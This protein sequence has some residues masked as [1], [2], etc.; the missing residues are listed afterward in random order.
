MPPIRVAL[1]GLSPSS[2]ASA[3]HIPYLTQ[4]SN[5]TYNLVAICNSS[6]SS[7]QAAIKHHNLPSSTKA[8]GSVHD[9]VA[10]DSSF[11]LA[12]CTVRVDSHYDVIK[13]LLEAGKD[14]FSEWPLAKNL[15]QAEELRDLAK[16]KGVRTMV[17]LQGRRGPPVQTIKRILESGRIGRVLSSTLVADAFNGGAVEI[18]KARFMLDRENG[19]GILTIHFAHLIDV[20]ITALGEFS[21]FNAITATQRPT[22]SILGP[23]KTIIE[24]DVKRDSPD[25][26]MLQGTLTSG[27]IASAHMRG[28]MPFKDSH[29]LLWRIYCES[30]EIR[31]TTT[32]PF[33]GLADREVKI[34]VHDAKI[35]TVETIESKPAEGDEAFENLEKEVPVYGKHEAQNVA[36]LYEVFAKGEEEKYADFEGAVVRHKMIK[37]TYKSYEEG[38]VGKY[39]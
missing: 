39:I 10:D 3:A 32:M 35:D 22:A 21:S 23:D 24:T 4:P 15:A 34:E 38:R 17:G 20:F 27:A 36:R 18:E 31:L 5:T 29:A 30:G 7:A 25:Q 19:G 6:I 9:L 12:V 11:D 1:I 37:E 14:V 26:V 33:L 2:W 8:Y 13:P 28:G 16:E